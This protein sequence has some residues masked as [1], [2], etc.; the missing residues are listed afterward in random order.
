MDG[1]TLWDVS[2]RIGPGSVGDDVRLVQYLMARFVQYDPVAPPATPGLTLSDVDG[3][4]GS[5]TTA[6]MRWIEQNGGVVADGV[7]DPCP[8][9]TLDV[10]GPYSQYRYKIA[11]LQWY[12]IGEIAQKSPGTPYPFDGPAKSAILMDMANDGQCPADLAWAL[13]SAKAELNIEDQVKAQFP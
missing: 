7:V 10:G 8:A 9:D 13:E 3:Q 11:L 4:W 12:Y 1:L 5:R 2:F 6:A